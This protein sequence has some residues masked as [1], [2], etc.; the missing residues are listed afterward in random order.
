MKA[1]TIIRAVCREFDVKRKDLL[2]LS[3]M[4]EIVE[5]RQVA[6]FLI[7]SMLKLS[8]RGIGKVFRRDHTTVGFGARKIARRV[9]RDAVL[10]QKIA[11]LK[12]E[13][14]RSHK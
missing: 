2:A 4:S 8:H 5:A 10:H 1:E 14:L 11:H 3:R 7:R 13:L 12:K 9:R 6:F